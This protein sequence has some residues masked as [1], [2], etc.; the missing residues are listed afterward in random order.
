MNLPPLKHQH[1]IYT[2]FR[3]YRF[4]KNM[5]HVVNLTIR[6]PVIVHLVINWLQIYV[7]GSLDICHFP[8]LEQ[9]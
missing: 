4:L 3:F 9:M 1:L 6:E 7:G 2:L 8:I 5:N